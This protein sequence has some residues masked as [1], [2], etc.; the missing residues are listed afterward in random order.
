MTITLTLSDE[1][2]SLIKNYASLH[3]ISIS[4]LFHQ[5]VM[6]KIEDEHDLQCYERAMQSRKSDPT[7]YTLGEVEK[8]LG[9]C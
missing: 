1:D 6:E 8:E 9:L 4:E 3:N 5:A 2:T 7:T